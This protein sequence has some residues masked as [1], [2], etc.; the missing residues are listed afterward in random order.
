MSVVRLGRP[1]KVDIDLDE[2]PR[3]VT[4]ADI[5]IYD[6]LVST[7]LTR[8]QVD[9]ILEPPRTYE[10][11]REVLA[12]HWHQEFVPLQHVRTRVDTLF[13]NREDELIVPTQHNV[14]SSYDG[15]HTGVEVDC[16]SAG[17]NRKVQLLLHFATEKLEGRSDVLQGMLD[18][19][20]KY[21]TGQLFEFLDSLIDDRFQDRV[22]EAARETWA[23]DDVVEFARA[24]GRRLKAMIDM[25]W[26]S[27]P[28]EMIKNKLLRNYVDE[29]RDA[30]GDPTIDHAQVFLRALKAI[31]K[32]NFALDYF[33]RT[34]EV[35]EEVRGIG[36]GIVIPHPEQFWPVLLDDLDVDGIEVWNPQSF[37]YTGFLIDVVIR[38]NRTRARSDRPILITMGDDCHMGEKVK[39][40]RHQD[41]AK[42]ARE[43]GVQPPWDD[44][45]VRKNLILAK[46]DRPHLI[47][48]YRAR[49]A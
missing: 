2:V 45:N 33:Y 15:R 12:V 7:E 11:Q 24:H 38:K 21:R 44:L 39:D 25:K 49:L 13:P 8:D 18:H 27:T 23:D 48:E 37:E 30:Y 32:R 1:A 34:E 3:E 6:R 43:V 14:L 5:E 35:V 31:V 9:R 42:A 4:E 36:G 29:W 47:R 20:F 41:A 40:P 26:Q 10:R 46:A 22:D 17:F 16:Y 19:T 28:R